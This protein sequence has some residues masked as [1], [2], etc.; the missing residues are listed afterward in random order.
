MNAKLGKQI[1]VDAKGMTVYLYDPDATSKTSTVPDGI[2]ASWPPVIATGAPG[3]GAGLDQ[4]KAA[5]QPQADGTSQVSYNGH[6]LYTFVGDKAPGDA[7][8]QGLGGIWFVLS[9]DGAKI[10]A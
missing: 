3:V 6:L 10:P 9:P 8:G 7:V 1:I 4:A 2:K 5:A